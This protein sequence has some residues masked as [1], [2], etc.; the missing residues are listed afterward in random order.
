MLLCVSCDK[1][2]VLKVMLAG[3]T[4]KIKWYCA[5]AQSGRRTSGTERRRNNTIQQIFHMLPCLDVFGD[6]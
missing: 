2:I 6:V 5:Y 1:Q 4:L 3:Y